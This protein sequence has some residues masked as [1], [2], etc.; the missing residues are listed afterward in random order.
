MTRKMLIDRTVKSLKKLPES[1]LIE[2]QDYIDF[3]LYRAKEKELNREI[4]QMASQSK[5]FRFLEE[6]EEL[7]ADS[8][9][10][11]LYA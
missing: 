11:E 7:Y 4:I 3:L 1:K 8:D 2:V 5:S 9:V 10:K 6:E